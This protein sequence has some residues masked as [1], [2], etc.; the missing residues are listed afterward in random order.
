MYYEAN[1]FNDWGNVSY[2][3]VN[4]LRTWVCGRYTGFN[5]SYTTYNT[6]IVQFFSPK[7]FYGNCGP[8][9]DFTGSEGVY[10]QWGWSAYL[11]W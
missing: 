4:N 11:N 5:Q 6:N 7:Y 2:L 10:G 3:S 8:Q 1:V 9:A